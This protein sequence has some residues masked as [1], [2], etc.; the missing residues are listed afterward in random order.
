MSLSL[1]HLAGG[2]SQN[3]TIAGQRH[4][5]SPGAPSNCSLPPHFP[6]G[7]TSPLFQCSVL[8]S[9]SIWEGPRGPCWASLPAELEGC[10]FPAP[11]FL[12]TPYR[13]ATVRPRL[14]Q[15]PGYTARHR[16]GLG[17]GPELAWG[18]HPCITSRPGLSSLQLFLANSSQTL[19][20][21]QLPSP[22]SRPDGTLLADKQ[23]QQ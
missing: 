3:T 21:P 1:E 13:A 23:I 8:P 15:R 12:Q 7:L 5:L 10:H 9:R 16:L 6:S 19:S 2:G 17:L 4:P 14:P 22:L 20:H 11:C 18:L